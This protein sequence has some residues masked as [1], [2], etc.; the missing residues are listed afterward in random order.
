M[1]FMLNKKYAGNYT[2]IELQ[3]NQLERLELAVFKTPL[4]NMI[5]NPSY[6]TIDIIGSITGRIFK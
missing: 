3:N 1:V 4:T 5:K 6:S 2:S